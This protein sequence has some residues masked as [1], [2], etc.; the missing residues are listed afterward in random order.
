MP[1][2]NSVRWA[3]RVPLME[4]RCVEQIFGCGGCPRGP[5]NLILEVIFVELGVRERRVSKGLKSV[6]LISKLEDLIYSFED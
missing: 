2:M 1:G 6:V 4:R 5:R 3:L